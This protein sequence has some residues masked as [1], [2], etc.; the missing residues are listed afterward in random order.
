MVNYLEPGPWESHKGSI[1]KIL[2]KINNNY[3]KN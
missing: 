2:I 3:Q 1:L